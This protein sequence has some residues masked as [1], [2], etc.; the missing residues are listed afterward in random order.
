MTA[1][2]ADTIAV[3]FALNIEC[4]YIDMHIYALYE[5]KYLLKML[6]VNL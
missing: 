2:K 3:L 6:K 1:N 4:I 5:G